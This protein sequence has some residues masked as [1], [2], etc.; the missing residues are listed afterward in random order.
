MA[1]FVKAVAE[2]EK[3]APVPPPFIVR[4]DR[5]PDQPRPIAWLPRSST[6]SYK[7]YDGGLGPHRRSIDIEPTKKIL[8]AE[9]GLVSEAGRVVGPHA[10]WL[11]PDIIDEN[12]PA[13]KTWILSYLLKLVDKDLGIWY[14]DK[15][16]QDGATYPAV[17][18]ESIRR[19]IEQTSQ[20]GQVANEL[21][22]YLPRSTRQ[23]LDFFFLSLYWLRKF[24]PERPALSRLLEEIS[25]TDLYLIPSNLY[26]H[27]PGRKLL[28]YYDDQELYLKFG[29]IGNKFFP[30]NYSSKKEQL[31]AIVAFGLEHFGYLEVERWERP[32]RLRF[33]PG[34][35]RSI[36]G[37]ELQLD[38]L[39]A[40]TGIPRLIILRLAIQVHASWPWLRDREVWEPLLSFV[41]GNSHLFYKDYLTSKQQDHL[42]SSEDQDK[43]MITLPM[44]RESQATECLV[45]GTSRPDSDFSLCGH[46]ICLICQALFKSARCPFC[47]EHFTAE[48]IRDDFIQLVRSGPSSNRDLQARVLQILEESRSRIFQFDW[49]NLQVQLFGLKLL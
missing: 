20:A 44:A 22:L 27:H 9:S 34:G 38:E 28:S 15:I 2:R 3:Y 6:W 14:L 43:V 40:A 13:V 32:V 4:F 24:R 21:G 36:P 46:P 29:R 49:A 30:K 7:D 19:V 25:H 31:D 10:I 37:T 12:D 47:T 39:L 45:C 48:A 23:S 18:Q 17:I 11:L 1:D 26:E 33:H 42:F 41:D 16:D 8:G 5:D 35:T